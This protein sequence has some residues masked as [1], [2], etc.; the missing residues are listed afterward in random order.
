VRIRA[1]AEAL[2]ILVRDPA[3]GYDR[4]RSKIDRSADRRRR[5][6][7]PSYEAAP[8]SE[9]RL[10]MHFGL[11]YPC[12]AAREFEPRWE[13]VGE[14]LAAS[15][16]FVGAWVHDADENLAR[17]LW[18]LV[19]HLRPERTV[20]TGVA[21]GITTR[22]LLEGL[23]RNGDGRLWSIDLP[24]LRTGWQDQTAVAVRPALLSR[25]TY[26]RGSSRRRLPKLLAS[27]GTIDLFLHDSAHTE[28]NMRFEFE[29]AWRA[30]RYGGVL[31]SHDV[32]KNRAFA[33]F[34]ASTSAESLLAQFT[35]GA[36]PVGVVFKES[37]TR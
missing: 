21:R 10:H 13:A 14:A 22:I 2:G 4:L 25:W 17:V 3:E 7:K 31:V 32:R 36:D 8:D 30:L 15:S 11:P 37:R 1:T 19:R 20:E 33:D 5:P 27:L 28:A 16:S 34:A 12:E 6:L 18:C 23:E 9:H 26:V 29:T 24:L 35:P